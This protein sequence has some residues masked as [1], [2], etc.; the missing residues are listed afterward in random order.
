[1][2][3]EAGKREL[4]EDRTPGRGFRGPL[5]DT[6]SHEIRMFGK[7]CWGAPREGARGVNNYEGLYSIELKPIG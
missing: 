4:P 1:M 7:K 5:R 3:A 2:A 6:A